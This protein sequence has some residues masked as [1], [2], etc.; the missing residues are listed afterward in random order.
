M[1]ALKI[2][3]EIGNHG[4]VSTEIEKGAQERRVRGFIKMQIK[5]VYIRVWLGKTVWLLSSNGGFV[6]MKKPKNRFKLLL[7]FEGTRR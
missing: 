3:T 2:F 6:K 1:S 7:G 5:A 4:L